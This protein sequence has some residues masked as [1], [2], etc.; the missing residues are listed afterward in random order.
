LGR[1][2]GQTVSAVTQNHLY[3]GLDI[4]LTKDAAGLPLARYLRG[5]AIDEPW[6]RSGLNYALEGGTSS[7]VQGWWKMNEGTGTSAADASGNGNTGTLTGGPTWSSG[8]AS[9]AVNLDGVN[10][11]VSVGDK[12][13]LEGNATWTFA[14]WI[15]PDTFTSARDTWL[16]YKQNVLQWGLLSGASRQMSVNIGGGGNN[17]L[18]GAVTNTVQ[19]SSNAWTHIAVTYT[20]S[21]VKFYVNGMLV[22][23]ISKTYTM[24]S[25]NK[26]FSI[27]TSSQSFDGKLD[28]MRYYNRAL[29]DTEVAGIYGETVTNRVYMATVSGSI[30][31]LTDNTKVI[32]TE[33]GYEPFGTTT[34]S[35][36]SSSNPYKFTARE[37]D[38][39]GL[40]YYRFRYYHT[41]LGRFISEDP[42]GFRG[43]MNLYGYALGNPISRIDP[44][45]LVDIYDSSLKDDVTK[46]LSDSDFCGARPHEEGGWIVEVETG[47]YD[48]VRWPIDPR[49]ADHIPVPGP[50]PENA[51]GC[52]H[53]HYE[54]GDEPSPRGDWR[55][56]QA[57]DKLKPGMDFLVIGPCHV[58]KVV[59]SQ[60]TG[61][62][63]H[64]PYVRPPKT[65]WP[66]AKNSCQCEEKE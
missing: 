34:A 4:V 8:I 26:A 61:Y 40:Y 10:D 21:T 58:W 50:P 41:G 15:N 46:L 39:T 45:G 11:Y 62:Y 55:T 54:P 1:R 52:V 5:L 25:N 29:S 66:G 56:K 12:G 23:T 36:A 42:L 17:S 22:D 20:N 16:L 44:L 6:Q 18:Q 38:G 24:G 2:V 65:A 9:N 7:G 27:S 64:I 53:T 31:A 30:V 63:R 51:V 59:P 60:T 37:D 3:D 19:L 48:I 14:G 57:L 32:A 43:G 13:T 28:D 33:Y 35:G 49:S 47:K